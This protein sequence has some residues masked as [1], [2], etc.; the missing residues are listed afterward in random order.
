MRPARLSGGWER[1]WPLAPA[2]VFACLTA[3]WIRRVGVE[4]MNCQIASGAAAAMRGRFPP[5]AFNYK[6]GPGMYF[7]LAPFVL[8]FGQTLRAIRVSCVFWSAAYVAAAG[9]LAGR[10]AGSRKAGVLG[11]CL[12]AVSPA[13]SQLTPLGQFGQIADSALVAAALA[14]MIA[15]A[16][17]RGVWRARRAGLLLGLALATHSVV[18]GVVAGLVVFALLNRERFGPPERRLI[19]QGAAWFTA[20]LLT[21]AW[22]LT[23]GGLWRFWLRAFTARD[24]G[25]SNLSYASSA[26]VRARQ[27]LFIVGGGVRPMLTAA[28]AACAAGLL[29]A[30]LW[31]F[32][33]AG[34]DARRPAAFLWTLGACFFA[35]SPFTPSVLRNVHLMLAMPIVWAALAASLELEASG[36]ARL[37][38]AMFA[39]VYLAAGSASAALTVGTLARSRGAGTEYKLAIIDM[40]RYFAARPE[41]SP[42]IVEDAGGALMVRFLS[43]R[44]PRELATDASSPANDAAWKSALGNPA[45]VLVVAAPDA[46]DPDQEG[47]AR[48]LAARAGYRLVETTVLRDGLGAPAYRFLTARR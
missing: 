14:E 39:C 36:P 33:R 43:E 21:Y 9:L 19:A 8:V 30:A 6:T 5:A 44:E 16:R 15:C 40:A 31:R 37:A 13:L 7:L 27:L 28:A 38:G 34:R 17:D 1:F 18:A 47:P 48:R 35:L 3:L 41:L 26:L 45:S 11:A 25:L 24:D 46:G 42:A 20:P 2:T 22:A 32:A 12:A 4:P 23:V 10:C 29:G